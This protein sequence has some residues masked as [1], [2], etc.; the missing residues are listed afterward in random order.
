VV[1]QKINVVTRSSPLARAQTDEA[2]AQIR[3]LLPDHEFVVHHCTSPG[4]RD[5]VTPLADARVPDDFFTRDLDEALLSG[6]ADL[7]IHSAKDLPTQLPAGCQLAALLPARDIR[8]ALV[9][10]P[11]PLR[12]IGTS[13]P[14]R[15]AQIKALYPD[16]VT[17]SI[18][19]TIEQRLAQLDNGDYDAVIIAACALDRL[20]LSDRIDRYLP[21][22][23]APQQGRLALVVSTRQPELMARLRAL[24]VRRRAGLVAIVGCPADYTLLSARALSYLDHADVVIHDRLL[25]DEV[26][27]RIAG[28]AVPVG[29]AGGAPST[30]QS[31]IHRRLLHEAE[32][33]KLVV[34]L[35]G[36]DPLIFAHLSEE[37]EFLTAW[38]L[39]VDLVPTLTAAQVAAAHAL[40]PLTHR[41][42]GGHLHLLSGH[43]PTGE[44]PMDFPGPGAGNT[45][46][47][48]GVSEAADTLHRLQKSGWPTET[49]VIVGERLGY[50]DEAIRIMPLHALA[51]Q[52]LRKPAVY[53]VGPRAF[54]TRRTL[55]TGTDPE[56]FLSHGP[57][58]H[59]PLIEL[60]SRPLAE[61][62]AQLA[63][64]WATI[65]GILFPSRFAVHSFMEALLADRDVR[66]L[67]GKKLLAVGP[68]T[69]DALRGYGCRADAAVDH[70]G[71]IR[72]LIAEQ[73]GNWGTRWLYPCSN[74]A[75]RP[76][77]LQTLAAAG[78]EAVAT[79]FYENRR[80]P[81]RPLPETPFE[82]V[83]FT[84]GST[85]HAYFDAY[86]AELQASRTWL[87]V[88]P[89]TLKTI[90]EKGLVADMIE[91]SKAAI[92]NS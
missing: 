25:P 47:Y 55:F 36:G 64:T 12:V 50:R 84:S 68:A 11:G 44:T 79:V 39:R 35:Q 29:K 88:G 16:A 90:E 40:A 5:V 24:D 85:V 53:L 78:V 13:S 56:H 27:Q 89:S 91:F 60:A 77:R 41:Q 1:P 19:G 34:R 23:T 38:N 26:V 32:Q 61:R 9:C 3:H 54:Q 8:D 21:Y 45:A 37:L 51:D 69:R 57:L 52:S 31:E 71:G 87:A 92:Q 15:E 63:D 30:L 49:E 67:Q 48:M 17:R 10:R 46:I 20:G 73:Q 7:A 14:T 66:A 28:K 62:Q 18:R 22:D 82:R 72:S 43:T 6:A 81:F 58:I 83:L 74:A 75:P 86:P 33:G 2:L 42:D 59:W 4:D 76:E 80:P 65:D 70:Y